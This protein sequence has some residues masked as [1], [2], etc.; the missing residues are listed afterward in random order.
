MTRVSATIVLVVCPVAL[1]LIY[2]LTLGHRDDYLGHFLGGFAAT[3]GA[4]TLALAAIPV[5][6][7]ASWAPPAV[8]ALTWACIAAGGV[9]EAT[10]YRIAKWDE[11]DFFNQSLGAALAGLCSLAAWGSHRPSDRAVALTGAWATMA[12]IGGYYFAF[13]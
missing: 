5:R 6:K 1:G 8:L 7:F 11:V 2:V 4:L 10:L 3:L 9:L 12:L 13:R